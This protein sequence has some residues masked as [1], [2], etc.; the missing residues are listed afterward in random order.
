MKFNLKTLSQEKYLIPL[1]IILVYIL[2]NVLYDHVL[3]P[4]DPFH[5]WSF[6]VYHLGQFYAWAASSILSLCGMDVSSGGITINM[7]A[8]HKFLFILEPCLGIQVMVIFSAAIAVFK[9]KLRDKIPFFL[10]GLT[11]IFLINLTRVTLLCVA[12]VYLTPSYFAIH[13]TYLFAIITYGFIFFMITR[14]MSRM[15]DKEAKESTKT[16]DAI[17]H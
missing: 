4:Y 5:I 10:I 6:M 16:P 9:G 17:V 3:K 12:W 7:L 14:W 1:K 15:I 2:W 11:G 13:H 8:S